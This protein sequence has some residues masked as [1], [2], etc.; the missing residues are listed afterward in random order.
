MCGIAGFAQTAEDC[1][2]L[3]P[4]LAAM[5][6]AI[7]HRGPDDEGLFLQERV[8]LGMRR[9]SIID[10]ATGRQP[11][12]NED[13]T[14]TI[15][16]NGEIYN[17]KT[18]RASLIEKGH[19]FSTEGDTETIVHAYEEYGE[20]CPA[21]LRGMFAFALWDARRQRLL[22]AR[23]RVGIK[24]L[25]YAVI[26]QTLYFAS[27]MKA[28]AGVPRMA[29]TISPAAVNAYLTFGYIPDPV[30]IYEEVKQVPAGET[31]VWE[32]G[33]LRLARYWEWPSPHGTHEVP[34]SAAEWETSLLSQL[35]ETVR[36]HLVSD[37][38]V[39]L[40]LS[41]GVD[42]SA[43]LALMA[44]HSPGRIQTI[45]V[46]FDG[47][48]FYDERPF[49]KMMSERY[50]T[51]HHEV[52]VRPQVQDILPSLI[53]AFDQ[54][55][56]D[57]S[58]IPTYH[59]SQVTGQHVKVALSG[60]GGDELFGGYERYLGGLWAQAYQ[61]IPIPIRTRIIAPLVLA[62]PDSKKGGPFSN[63]AKRFVQT[64][65]L[66]SAARYLGM[67]SFFSP[68]ARVRLLSQDFLGAIDPTQTEQDGR[69]LFESPRTDSLLTRMLL[70]DQRRYLPC[71]LL[72]LTDRLS[73][74]H[75][76]EVRVPFLDHTFLEFAMS[77][78]P[79]MKIHGM[80]K[81]RILKDAFAPLL[82]KEILHRRK[83]GFS[84]PLAAW[85][86]K[87]LREVVETYL[88][89][90][91]LKSV[92]AFNAAEVRRILDDHMSYRNN[93]ENQ[94]WALLVFV[95]WHHRFHSPHI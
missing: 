3:R 45:S 16:F 64:A 8:G 87:E 29:R 5:C 22:L 7:R 18:L 39:G 37:V 21:F 74:A 95:L 4:L 32:N 79:E 43:V 66:D 30:T 25:Y 34:R 27:E 17:Y 11:I 70:F 53:H 48:A 28:F 52:V 91:A 38:P 83:R 69:A 81:K 46:G 36:L 57:S 24:P 49:A 15:V 72:V 80:V 33:K 90:K 94:I 14:V 78:P 13:G 6:D 60:L 10:L 61:R 40:F 41:G 50:G 93:Y 65:D 44:R 71:D 20:G 35:D 56:A 82:P 88:G 2:T 19:R 73:M 92:A 84:V 67:I 75:S 59:V 1:R 9:L 85:I 55:F 58:A 76:L 47:D 63:R 62:L 31:L 54:P 12:S 42:S 26:H 51:E 77:I 89:E 23:D 68:E 86:R